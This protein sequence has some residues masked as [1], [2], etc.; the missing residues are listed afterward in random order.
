V[1]N[2]RSLIDHRVKK[3]CS[4]FDE[5]TSKKIQLTNNIGALKRSKQIIDE[6]HPA[7]IQHWEDWQPQWQEPL[8]LT[9]LVLLFP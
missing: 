1:N 8:F 5:Q 2:Q 4:F 6:C 9:A 3:K 7:L